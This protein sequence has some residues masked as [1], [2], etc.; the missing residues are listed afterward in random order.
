MKADYPPLFA[1]GFHDINCSDIPHL[2]IEPFF[3]QE[4]REKLLN[5][6]VNLLEKLKELHLDLEIWLDGSFAT[7]KL[8]P[9]DVDVAVFFDISQINSLDEER[10]R[11]I[12]VLSVTIDTKTRYN[13]DVYFIP[14]HD[15]TT[16]S[17]WRGWFGFS[18]SE[19]PKGI[20]RLFI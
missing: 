6:L 8:E 17:Y 19:I 16:R 12:E 4:R 18:R 14:N 2:F 13:C 5:G 11:I 3:V 10:K 7:L 1:P 15:D 9:E 20:P